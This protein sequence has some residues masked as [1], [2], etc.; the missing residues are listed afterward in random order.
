[1]KLLNIF[2]FFLPFF[3]SL[4]GNT[5]DYAIFDRIYQKNGWRGQESV[6]GVG[7]DLARTVAVREDL[8]KLFE[9]FNIKT[10]LDVPCG[11]FNWMKKLDLSRLT[12]YIGGDIVEALIMRNK[13]LF[14]KNNISFSVINAVKDKLPCVDLILCRDLLVHLPFDDI[15][16]VLKNMKSSGSTFFLA[17]TFIQVTKNI[18]IRVGSW[19][20]LDLQKDP[21]NFPSPLYIIDESRDSDMAHKYKRL[22]LWRLEDL[23]NY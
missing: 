1:M 19:R 7:S 5:S 6:S 17:T 21:F 16:M 2:I 3:N 13:S 11:D 4:L 22:A 8:P 9:Q 15:K 12:S 14:E 10:L 20:R 18:D 23:P